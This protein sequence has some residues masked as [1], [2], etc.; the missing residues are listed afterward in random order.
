[1]ARE[2]EQLAAQRNMLGARLREL[3]RADGHTQAGF[4]RSL[5]LGRYERTSIAHIESGRQ[6]APR[7]FWE[8]ADELLGASGELVD[9]FDALDKARATT[10]PPPVKR[11]TRTQ[12]AETPWAPDLGDALIAAVSSWQRRAPTSTLPTGRRCR[13][14]MALGRRPFRPAGPDPRTP[15]RPR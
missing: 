6:P 11:P 12:E 5:G 2:P 4:A 10:R 15:D 9:A 8:A 7:E 14:A 13:P 3:R 1:M